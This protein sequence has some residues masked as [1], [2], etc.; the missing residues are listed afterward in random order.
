MILLTILGVLLEHYVIGVFIGG[1]RAVTR[2][3]NKIEPLLTEVITQIQTTKYK[4]YKLEQ[5]NIMIKDTPN[6]EAQAFGRG[7]LLLTSGLLNTCSDDELKGV[8][9]NLM[10]HFYYKDSVVVTA[11]LCSSFIM[12][13]VIWI[14]A[15]YSVISTMFASVKHE[16]IQLMSLFALVPLLIFL[17]II[18]LNWVGSRVL[19]LSLRA[20][21]RIYEYRADKF[22]KSLGNQAGLISF[23]EKLQLIEKPD[24]SFMGKLLATKPVPMKRVDLLE[25]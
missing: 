3:K 18:V 7:T 15:V 24:N 4:G 1:R 16:G 20:M 25:K 9:S 23:L 10:G 11:V 22:A 5:F 6:I 2:E 13:I 21:N 19:N 14:Y 17:P 8:L 12:R